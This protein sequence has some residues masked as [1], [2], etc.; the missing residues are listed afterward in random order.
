MNDFH[1]TNN[2]INKGIKK[3]NKTT[4]TGKRNS[5]AHKFITNVSSFRSDLNKSNINSNILNLLLY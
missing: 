3:G 5:I 1:D 2:I 4:I